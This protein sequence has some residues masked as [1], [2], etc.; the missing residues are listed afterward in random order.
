MALGSIQPLTEMSTRS[1]FW[2][3]GGRCGRLTTLPPSCAVVMKAGNLKFLEPSGPLQ[4]Y[5][6]TAVPLNRVIIQWSIKSLFSCTLEKNK[7]QRQSFGSWNELKFYVKRP[8]CRLPAFDL[9][10]I[11]L[12]L[13]PSAPWRQRG[14]WIIQYVTSRPWRGGRKH[15]N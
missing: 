7:H 10:V 1:I 8:H 15:N 3:K 14:H 11:P 6:G 4:A 12:F 5:N 2:G 13:P 9:G